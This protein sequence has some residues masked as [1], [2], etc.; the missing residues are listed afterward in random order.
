MVSIGALINDL[1]IAGLV[2]FALVLAGA[3]VIKRSRT[4]SV[5]AAA[6]LVALFASTQRIP[7][8]APSAVRTVIAY[9][10]IGGACAILYV[11]LE[12]EPAGL[13]RRLGFRRRSVEWE[14]D[15]EL[16][17]LVDAFNR[18]LDVGRQTRPAGDRLDALHEEA[19]ALVRELR[20]FPPPTP[21]WQ[22]VAEAYIRLMDLHLDSLGRAFSAEEL[23]EYERLLADVTAERERRRAAYRERAERL[24][25][26]P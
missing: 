24:F 26:W 9:A 18:V 10:L 21:E 16:A 8:Q 11:A 6:S 22:N 15:R 2:L 25:R 5:A 7:I 3:G 23:A 12:Q 20:E 19:E 4:L 13:A 14:F 17:R 1:L